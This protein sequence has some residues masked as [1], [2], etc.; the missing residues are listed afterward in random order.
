MNYIEVSIN[1]PADNKFI[2]D[3]LIAFLAEQGFD[4][5]CED[6]NI[7]SAYINEENFNKTEVELL[8]KEYN[9]DHFIKIIPQ[10]NWNAEWE[11][12]FDPIIVENQL[13]IKAPFHNQNFDTRFIIEIEP[14]M[15]F[16]TGHH[17]TTY[18]M[19]H[20]MADYVFNESSVLDMGCGTG[21]LAIYAALKGA[22]NI[23][24]I[25]IDEWA[26]EN[27]I[28]NVQ[29]NNIE[30]IQTIMGDVNFIPDRQF[31]YILANINLNILK[32]DI[33]AYV[34]HMKKGSLLF[35]SGFFA[36]E[37]PQINLICKEN[38]LCFIKSIEKENWTAC[39]FNKI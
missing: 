20:L 33:P 39:V 13:T 23:V 12:N 22:E 25:D 26:Y 18:M 32:K 6:N 14:K 35:L 16:G 3:I 34:E 2:A 36:S 11:K 8:M 37:L 10:Q 17:A 7:L 27:T 9:V 15:S 30:N 1:I 5:F 31:D 28:E 29:R 21:I 38:N 4:S 24:A 19:C